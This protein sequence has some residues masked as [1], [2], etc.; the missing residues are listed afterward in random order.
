MTS[1]NR[2]VV[3]R[4]DTRKNKP[5]AKP[6]TSKA[7]RVKGPANTTSAPEALKRAAIDYCLGCADYVPDPKTSDLCIRWDNCQERLSFLPAET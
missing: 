4:S 7:L 3:R 1:R 5:P 6:S 2:S